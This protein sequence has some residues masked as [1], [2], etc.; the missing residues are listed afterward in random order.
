MHFQ[1]RKTALQPLSLYRPCRE[2]S[3]RIRSRAFVL[4]NSD[5]AHF[6]SIFPC[7]F[8]SIGNPPSLPAPD[9]LSRR[10][11]GQAGLPGSDFRQQPMVSERFCRLTAQLP[12]FFPMRP[13]ACALPSR[14]PMGRTLSGSLFF[15]QA[16]PPLSTA[17]FVLSFDGYYLLASGV[18]RLV[19]CVLPLPSSGKES[20]FFV[21]FCRIIRF[22]IAQQQKLEPFRSFLWKGSSAAVS[23][24][25][26]RLHR[27]LLVSG[28]L[29]VNSRGI[30]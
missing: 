26:S 8:L 24:T 1:S 16:F 19:S 17:V 22:V 3:T 12:R 6:L 25:G 2:K 18:S 30:A 14:L 5:P 23:V 4:F 13:A 20:P 21:F 28:Q 10:L 11:S 15:Q 9:P 29:P 27:R 7:V